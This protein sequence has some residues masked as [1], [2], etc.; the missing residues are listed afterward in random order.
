MWNFKIRKVWRRLAVSTR[1]GVTGYGC[2]PTVANDGLL[3]TAQP[4]LR[5]G[6]ETLNGA[7]RKCGCI[8]TP[9]LTS[10]PSEIPQPANVS[11]SQFGMFTPFFGLHYSLD[12]AI[13]GSTGNEDTWRYVDP[14]APSPDKIHHE[15][16]T[17]FTNNCQTHTPLVSSI[18]SH[19]HSGNEKRKESSEVKGSAWEAFIRDW[20][21]ES[22]VEPAT[23]GGVVVETSMKKTSADYPGK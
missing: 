4:S 3:R 13:G 7:C 6:E 16:S 8:P 17:P 10:H 11:L 12:D 19:H 9:P 14:S 20:K 1:L 2:F 5:S 18:H 22:H 15:R 21:I 23:K